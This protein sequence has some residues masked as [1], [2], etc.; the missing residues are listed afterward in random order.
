M[1]VGLTEEKSVKDDF[2][3]EKRF[4][5]TKIFFYFCKKSSFNILIIIVFLIIT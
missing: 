1:H 4:L 3:F 5:N 2:E